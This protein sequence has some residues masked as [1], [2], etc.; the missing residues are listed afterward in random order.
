MLLEN[1]QSAIANT[2]VKAFYPENREC[3]KHLGWEVTKEATH[4][5]ENLQ[6][7]QRSF[8]NED[9]FATHAVTGNRE[10]RSS[11]S[12]RGLE[13]TFLGMV[14]FPITSRPCTHC[15]REGFNG[16]AIAAPPCKTALCS[17]RQ[18]SALPVEAQVH[19][20]ARCALPDVQYSYVHTS[21]EPIRRDLPLCT[22]ITHSFCR[23]LTEFCRDW[24]TP[25]TCASPYPLQVKDWN[26]LPPH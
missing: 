19:F 10:L 2:V 16:A 17:A 7:Q 6:P 21:F 13:T 5:L 12:R 4:L 26:K 18:I 8:Q 22:Q 25:H 15:L 24:S 9:E 20:L 11:P 14:A 3:T 1:E 23:S